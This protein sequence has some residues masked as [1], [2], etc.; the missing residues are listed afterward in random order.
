MLVW[1]TLG[2]VDEQSTE[3]THPRF[4]QLARKFGNCR[5]AFRQKK[6]FEEFLFMNSTFIV[7]SIEEMTEKT[8]RKWVRTKNDE[9]EGQGDELTE[10]D[11]IGTALLASTDNGNVEV[12]GGEG[13]VENVLMD[14]EGEGADGDG[15]AE[16]DND[17]DEEEED[18]IEL[19]ETAELT[20]LEVHINNN[21]SY[22]GFNNV[23]TKIH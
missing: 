7:E 10:F 12:F 16:D 4:N 20:D 5:G 2:G 1:R 14:G 15:V 8:K 21:R 17:E 23:N 22:H 18:E 3:G 9:A 13:A 19:M 6:V 11:R